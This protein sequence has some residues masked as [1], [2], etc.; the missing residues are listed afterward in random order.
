V[1][2]DGWVHCIVCS[3][4]GSCVLQKHALHW[5]NKTRRVVVRSQMLKLP[6][7]STKRC[8]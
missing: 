6:C 2:V 5:S 7:L 3:I 4:L 8:G 1:G